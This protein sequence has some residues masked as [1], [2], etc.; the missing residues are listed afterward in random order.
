[1]QIAVGVGGDHFVTLE[2]GKLRHRTVARMQDLPLI[3]RLCL[4]GD[5]LNVVFGDHRM[6]DG[7]DGHDH[8]T[9]LRRHDGNVLFQRSVRRSGLDHFHLFAAAHHRH[10]GLLDDGDDLTAAW[11]GYHL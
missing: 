2:Y 6:F 11:S 8:L 4:Q 10:T 1:M 5:P 7:S 9:L 3:A